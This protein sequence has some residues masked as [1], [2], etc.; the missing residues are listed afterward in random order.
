MSESLWQRQL[1]DGVEAM[2]LDLSTGQQEALLAFLNLLNKW[3][4]A[5]NLTAVREPRQMV[6]RQ[7]LD[8]LTLMPFV[9]ADRVLDVGA[10]VDDLKPGDRIRLHFVFNVVTHITRAGV[11]SDTDS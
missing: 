2:G 7:L 9:S 6:P 5:Y 8:S 11:P 10:G 1:F 4:R 3:N